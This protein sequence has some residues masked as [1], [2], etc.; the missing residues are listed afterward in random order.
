LYFVW[1]EQRQD[2]ADPGIFVLGRDVRRTFTARPD[3][4]FVIKLSY[5]FQR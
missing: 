4:V 5:W 1:T 2:L 3:N